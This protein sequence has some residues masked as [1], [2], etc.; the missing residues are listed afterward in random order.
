MIILSIDPGSEKS[1]FVVFDSKTKEINEM[2]ILRN[3]VLKD[4]LALYDICEEIPPEEII[5]IIETM[6]YVNG[7]QSVVDTLIWVGKFEEAWG[8]EYAELTRTKIK[9]ILK[10]SGKN[11][12]GKVRKAVISMYPA[13]G[14]GN[15]PQIGI[16]DDR[17]LLYGVKD[18][19]W[20][21]L[22][23]GIAW[24]MKNGR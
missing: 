20:Q 17:G 14:G 3:E 22:G 23:A 24:S 6:G 18:H 4:K 15:C 2:G 16:K 21:A 10:A 9:S 19:I 5:L 13:K 7:G 8:R 12:D 1:G 11:A